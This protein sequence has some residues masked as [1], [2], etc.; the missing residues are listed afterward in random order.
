MK[1]QSMYIRLQN[2]YKKLNSRIQKSIKNGKFYQ[3]TQFKQEQLFARLKRYSLQMKQVAAGVAVVAALGVATPATAQYVPPA[4]LEHDG[5]TNPIEGLFNVGNLVEDDRQVFVDVDGDGDYDIFTVEVYY[6]TQI[7]Y[8]S[9]EIKYHENVGT[10]TVPSFVERTGALNPLDSFKHIESLEFVDIDNDGDMDCFANAEVNAIYYGS[11]MPFCTYIENIGSSTSP[12]FQQNIGTNN[13]LD[14]LNGLYPAIGYHEAKISFVDINNDG[15]MDCFVG[16]RDANP[17]AARILYF[18]NQGS[19]STPNFIKQP[20]ANNP[21]DVI[22]NDGNITPF[23]T[24][25]GKMKIEFY[26]MDKDGDKDAFCL[27]QGVGFYYYENQGNVSAPTFTSTFAAIARPL[28]SC[29]IILDFSLVDIDNDGDLDGFSVHSNDVF[30]ENLDTTVVSGIS[31]LTAEIPFSIFPNPTKGLLKFETML[32][33]VAVLYNVTGQKLFEQELEQ[34]Q[35]LDLSEL[36][37]GL[38]FLYI[39]TEK[40]RIRKK[41]LV[42]K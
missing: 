19:A 11:G 14:T 17:A 5:A 18:E 16:I 9:K 40:M 12:V 38:Y 36:D 31:N 15:D 4:F 1:K 34:K 20:A 29:T 24:N 41:V 26:D 25:V 42:Q 23:A 10:A 35:E 13:P 21:L 39:E 2:Q 3:F 7:S 28:D 22:N 6:S 27:G 33:G 30:W 37:N 32:S 8:N